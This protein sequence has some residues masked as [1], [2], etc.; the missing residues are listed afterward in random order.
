MF[1]FE[2]VDTSYILN[3]LAREIVTTVKIY[4]FVGSTTIHSAID[5]TIGY[6]AVK[7]V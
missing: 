5:S 6:I 1:N 2:E 7:P 3:V 4:K